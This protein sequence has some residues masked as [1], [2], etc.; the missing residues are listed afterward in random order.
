LDGEE[1]DEEEAADTTDDDEVEWY[2]PPPPPSLP[3]LP[4]PQMLPALSPP[5]NTSELGMSL[6]FYNG[7]GKAEMVVYKRVIPDGLTH[8]VHQQD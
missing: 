3:S 7:A 5:H 8:T 4:P 1:S 6:S 2:T